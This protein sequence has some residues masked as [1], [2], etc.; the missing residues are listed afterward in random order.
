[1][2]GILRKFQ[3]GQTV[4]RCAYALLTMCLSACLVLCTCSYH[5]LTLTLLKAS[6]K[7]AQQLVAARADAIRQVGFVF[8]SELPTFV[9]VRTGSW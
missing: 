2:I 9:P 5:K 1:L 8:F 4:P 3:R 6:W 7:R